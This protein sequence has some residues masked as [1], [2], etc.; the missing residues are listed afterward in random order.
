MKELSKER[1]RACH[2]LPGCHVER[3]GPVNGHWGGKV[4][5]ETG[6]ERQLHYVS[7]CPACQDYRELRNL[8]I[9][10]AAKRASQLM[11]KRKKREDPKQRQREW[12]QIFH[13]EIDKFVKEQG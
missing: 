2:V 4:T 5:T 11:R 10:G 3:Q 1:K 6:Y 9:P 12:C 8:A 13:A 7:D